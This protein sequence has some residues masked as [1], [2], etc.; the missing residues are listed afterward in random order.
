M[1]AAALAGILMLVACKASNNRSTATATAGQSR[2]PTAVAG[3]AA[4]P[5]TAL[6]Q[7]STTVVSRPGTPGQIVL[8]ANGATPDTVTVQAGRPVTFVNADSVPHH[9][10]SVEAGLFDPG[11]IAPGTSAQ[12]TVA[13]AGLH[14]WHDAANP[15][16]SGTIRV[17]P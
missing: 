7:P 10:V 11:T 15:R 1:I 9:P 8:S 5:R 12:V 13:A 2:A 16:L 17:V 3:T 6:A 4:P 14:D